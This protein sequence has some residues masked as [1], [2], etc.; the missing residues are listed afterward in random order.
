MICL[1]WFKKKISKDTFKLRHLKIFCAYSSLSVG[2]LIE[3][4]PKILI[5]LVMKIFLT[6]I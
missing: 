1:F 6:G 3:N 5:Y 2:I 4:E